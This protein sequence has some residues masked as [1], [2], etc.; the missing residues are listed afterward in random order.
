MAVKRNVTMINVIT[1]IQ[2]N[3]VG[4]DRDYCLYLYS[5]MFVIALKLFELSHDGMVWLKHYIHSSSVLY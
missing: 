1:T 2:G 5:L 3:K 4:I